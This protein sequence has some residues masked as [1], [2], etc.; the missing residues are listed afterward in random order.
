M[1][2]DLP[3]EAD[4]VL[5]EGVCIMFAP[6]HLHLD[7][8]PMC[9]SPQCFCHPITDE[10]DQPDE[11]ILPTYS[12][13]LVTSEVDHSVGSLFILLVLKWTEVHAMHASILH[14]WDSLSMPKVRRA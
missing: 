13:I 11:L 2:L 14:R 6:S 4:A 9:I 10:I 7:L 1:P 8:C 12:T 3:L 5:H